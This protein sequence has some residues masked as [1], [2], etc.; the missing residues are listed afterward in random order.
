MFDKVKAYLMVGIV[1]IIGFVVAVGFPILLARYEWLNNLLMM[2]VLTGS[3]VMWAAIL[4]FKFRDPLDSLRKNVLLFPR[5][6]IVAYFKFL[7]LWFKS[8]PFILCYGVICWLSFELALL[9]GIDDPTQKRTT[10]LND[11]ALLVCSIG[12]Q[13]GIVLLFV[14]RFEKQ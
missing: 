11:C 14:K 2:V 12:F 1:F 10:F 8:L 13:L 7:K 5:R 9:I 4:F 6:C 3:L